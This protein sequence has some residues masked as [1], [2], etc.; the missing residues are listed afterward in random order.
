MDVL[1]N[2]VF[3]RATAADR[4]LQPRPGRY[5]EMRLLPLRWMLQS[6]GAGRRLVEQNRGCMRYV[7]TRQHAMCRVQG[8]APGDSKALPAHA[9]PH[10]RQAGG[11]HALA[12]QLDAAACAGRACGSRGRARPHRRCNRNL[13]QAVPHWRGGPKTS[14]HP[15]GAAG[16][17]S[18][19]FVLPA[20]PPTRCYHVC[21]A[22]SRCGHPTLTEL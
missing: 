8:A 20:D 13:Y 5:S 12:D 18:P 21:V 3:S 14:R 9:Q 16:A 6:G 15:P 17:H 4:C 1:R 2:A 11:K 10:L 22:S 19:P 7:G